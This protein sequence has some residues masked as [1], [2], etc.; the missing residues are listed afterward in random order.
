MNKIL[1]IVFLF[2]SFAYRATSQA[3]EPVN[4]D[5]PDQSDGTYTL[6]KKF[7]QLETGFTYGKENGSYI[8]HNTMLRYGLTSK[9]E[10][11][12]LLDYGKSNGETGIMPVGVS[13]KHQIVSPKGWLPDITAVGYLRLPFLATN[14]FR[15]DKIPAS[16]LLAFQN[17]LSDKLS[18]GYNFGSSFDG[19]SADNDWIFTI[20]AGFA[21]TEVLSFFAEYFSQFSNA[22]KP[23]HNMD[24]GAMWLLKNNLQLDMAIGSTLFKDIKNRFITIGVTY[25]FNR[26]C[27]M[28]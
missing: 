26:R 28:K 12:F 1:P 10:F 25:R 6:P 14:N 23:A 27:C 24:V 21:P 22:S 19:E 3:T 15:P 17:D 8:F 13:I 16:L 18:V 2:L 20:S 5:R 7:Y 4:S 11:R 9:T